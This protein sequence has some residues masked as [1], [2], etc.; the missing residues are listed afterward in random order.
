[1]GKSKET[2][3]TSSKS[4]DSDTTLWSNLGG[5]PTDNLCNYIL[6][7]MN[8]NNS[9]ILKFPS[10][11]RKSRRSHQ[12]RRH[13]VERESSDEMKNLKLILMCSDS[14]LSQDAR[15]KKTRFLK[16]LKENKK[17]GDN[18]NFRSSSR[19]SQ[20]QKNK[21]KI[22]S[23]TS[24]GSLGHK[25]SDIN[26]LKG[27]F[28]QLTKTAKDIGNYSNVNSK[29]EIRSTSSSRHRQ[30]KN[31]R[32]KTYDKSPKESDSNRRRTK[33][34]RSLSKAS[35]EVTFDELL[36]I[37]NKVQKP[38]KVKRGTSKKDR[39][40]K[41]K[42]VDK[43]IME[44]RKNAQQL[45][46]KMTN[47]SS[48][49]TAEFNHPP[50]NKTS[51]QVVYKFE[52]DNKTY[53]MLQ[54]ENNVTLIKPEDVNLSEE[55]LEQHVTKNVTSE[56]KKF[57]STHLLQNDIQLLE[58]ATNISVTLD[59]MNKETF[60]AETKKLI[61]NHE[62]LFQSFHEEDDSLK[63]CQ[64]ETST[65][66]ST[67]VNSNETS[68]FDT[69]T[70][71]Q[72]A[73]LN[74]GK[75]LKKREDLTE[76]DESSFDTNYAGYVDGKEKNMAGDA[77]P[78][79]LI[80][81]SELVEMP[82]NISEPN[83]SSST[84]DL[85]EKTLT[86]VGDQ[87][88]SSEKEDSALSQVETPNES[89]EYHVEFE[90]LPIYTESEGDHQEQR[91]RTTLDEP[92]ISHENIVAT[93]VIAEPE[94]YA[95]SEH[96]VDY[97]GFYEE[98]DSPTA[99]RDVRVINR[100]IEGEAKIDIKRTLNPRRVG[101]LN[102]HLDEN[103][104]GKEQGKLRRFGSTPSLDSS[105]TGDRFMEFI[106]QNEAH[107]PQGLSGRPMNINKGRS[108]GTLGR[109]RSDQPSE[110]E[111]GEREGH[112]QLMSEVRYASSTSNDQPKKILSRNI[113]KNNKVMSSSQDTQDS[114][115]KRESSIIFYSTKYTESKPSLK[116]ISQPAIVN[117]ALLGVPQMKRKRR[118]NTVGRQLMKD[119]YI[120]NTQDGSSALKEMSSDQKLSLRGVPQRVQSRMTNIPKRNA[121]MRRRTELHKV[122]RVD[123]RTSEGTYS[124]HSRSIPY[125]TGS[126]NNSSHQKQRSSISST[127]PYIAVTHKPSTTTHK[128]SYSFDR[129][130][131]SS[132][133]SKKSVMRVDSPKLKKTN[134]H[135]KQAKSGGSPKPSKAPSLAPSKASAT[136]TPKSGG[137][138]TGKAKGKS[139]K[140]G[141]AGGGDEFEETR[142]VSE[143]ILNNHYGR[144]W[145]RYATNLFDITAFAFSIIFLVWLYSGY[146]IIYP[147]LV[148]LLMFSKYHQVE[149]AYLPT[150]LVGIKLVGALYIDLFNGQLP[151][152]E[153]SP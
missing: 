90:S 32:S 68:H 35:A 51:G 18:K 58:N 33:S 135:I 64:K 91:I 96:D 26:R 12:K 59:E 137:K 94:T 84:K 78:R 48:S 110:E 141:N 93:K 145:L 10:P 87:Y 95:K 53:Q 11:H 56:T 31:R 46:S 69:E 19:R 66:I 125:V 16:Y 138:K 120:S 67:A 73:P 80:I 34:K 38:E 153:P 76:N 39:R 24:T 37:V 114:G 22:S 55:L 128:T 60:N 129:R 109:I 143:Q 43:Q 50:N 63:T 124:S 71:R 74:N 82:E 88:I 134:S 106:N 77:T 65:F 105:M 119:H 104:T 102:V 112:S 40:S 131:S 8:V 98:S 4:D 6:P 28:S 9:N 42:K 36:S 1:M 72:S 83:D 126:I 13:K 115:R 121:M 54:F 139:G 123:R 21:K 61:S 150:I 133:T 23:I 148:I 140:K 25:Q 41:K 142:M 127:K 103:F 75:T 146:S 113:T 144:I 97:E 130:H 100:Q 108:F 89:Y 30:R 17:S 14:E 111:E 86:D 101:E 27:Y 152:P 149:A 47:E 3:N 7:E 132:T 117:P 85:D 81:N 99:Q 62:K 118:S 52:K 147:I 44:K 151:L 5:P 29:G 79:F 15:K 2:L 122:H 70:V 20:K 136:K 92:D 45:I 116:S 107:K 57:S 49:Q